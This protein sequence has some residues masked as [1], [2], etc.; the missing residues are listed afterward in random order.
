MELIK[1]KYL[2]T[3]DHTAMRGEP[4]TKKPT[5]CLPSSTKPFTCTTVGSIF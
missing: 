2:S 5:L 3:E 1:V 4:S